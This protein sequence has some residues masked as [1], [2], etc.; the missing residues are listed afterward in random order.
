MRDFEDP[1][2]ADAITNYE[3]GLL[4]H[5]DIVPDHE[6]GVMQ[7]HFETSLLNPRSPLE[8]PLVFE[9]IRLE[10][11]DVSQERSIITV[12]RKTAY[13]YRIGLRTGSFQLPARTEGVISSLGTYITIESRAIDRQGSPSPASEKVEF[14][15]AQ[16]LLAALNSPASQANIQEVRVRKL[17]YQQSLAEGKLTTAQHRKIEK[18]LKKLRIK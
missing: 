9:P 5:A 13:Q 11:P 7:A 1:G 6:F 18:A 4:P 10:P 17:A 8:S 14:T 12:H 16:L 15:H 2:L 3:R